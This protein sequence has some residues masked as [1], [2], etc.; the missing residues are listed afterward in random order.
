MSR[1]IEGPTTG[2]KGETDRDLSG[3]A[4][5]ATVGDSTA[6]VAQTRLVFTRAILRLSFGQL[7]DFRAATKNRGTKL[8]VSNFMV[9]THGLLGGWLG[10]DLDLLE[11]IPYQVVRDSL[12]RLH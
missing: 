9:P 1:T 7:A 6:R 2:E 5:P 4:I 12:Y 10:T 8:S 3:Q 11:G